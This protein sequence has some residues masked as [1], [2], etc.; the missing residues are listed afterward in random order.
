MSD[1]VRV[2]PHDAGALWQVV[3]GAGN[4]NILD[5]ATMRELARVFVD[6]S[7]ANDLKA[8]CLEGAGADFSFGASVQEHQSGQ[9]QSMLETL[10]GLVL[11]LL[12]CHVVTVAAVRGRCLGGGLEL[13][14]ICHR[15]FATTEAKFGQPEIALGVFPPL[16]SIVLPERVGRA[17]AE[18]L[19]LSGRTMAATEARDIGL[20]DELV[21]DD[22]AE[23]ALGWARSQLLPHSASSLR[24]AVRAIRASLANRIRGELPELEKLYADQLMV[25]SDA[26]EGIRAFLEKRRPI[27]KNR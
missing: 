16:A 22:P 2:V 13:V 19:C 4:G 12:D 23:A 24:F 18:E 1:L 7:A 25:T 3:F 14:A 9:V 6:A 5:R 11:D 27:W 17:R 15:V 21:N 8:I 20:V 10:R 26:N